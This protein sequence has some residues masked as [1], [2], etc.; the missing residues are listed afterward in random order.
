M[1]EKRHKSYGDIVLVGDGDNCKITYEYAFQLR[2]WDT[3]TTSLSVSELQ[4]RA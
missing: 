1:N 4:G 3:L 2:E